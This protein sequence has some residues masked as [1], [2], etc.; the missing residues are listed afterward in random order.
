MNR[1]SFLDLLSRYQQGHCTENEKLFVEQWYESLGEQD[2]VNLSALDLFNMSERVSD[3]LFQNIPQT[4]NPIRRT[5]NWY[6]MGVAASIGIVLAC[7][8]IYAYNYNNAEAAF[9]KDNI[10]SELISKTNTSTK[11]LRVELNDHTVVTLQPNA[12][13]TF[14]AAFSKDKRMVYLKGDAFFSVTKN[15]DKPLYVFNNKLRVRVL[16]TSFFVR[17]AAGQVA[18]S[19][20]KV[21]VNENTGRRLFTFLKKKQVKGVLVTPNQKAV[22]DEQH[23]QISK[24]LVDKPLPLATLNH[25]PSAIN[26]KFSETS[27]AE[28]FELLS[29][30]YGITINLKDP[31][32]SKCA[33]TG[34][35][36]NKG[37]YEQL[38][39]ICQSISAS[40]TVKGTEIS[41][42]ANN[43][44]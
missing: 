1:T 10:G 6:K 20:G 17:D 38:D 33:F 7:T 31:E 2:Q 4:A 43:C 36:N 27:L 41:I 37:L 19:T 26:L 8:A 30:V 9:K 12:S 40:Y 23:E 15:P 28:I 39:L 22:F 13:I 25:T 14:P 44:N 11:V 34:D 24:T 32:T 5:I 18:V 16:G 3:R 29:K 35:I 21:E 42:T